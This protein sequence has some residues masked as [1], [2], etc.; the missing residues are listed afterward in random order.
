MAGVP[1]GV[2]LFERSLMRA[3]QEKA[4]AQ[5]QRQQQEQAATENTRYM[6]EMALKYGYHEDTQEGAA[7][8]A[9]ARA[10]GRVRE[11]ELTSRDRLAEMAFLYDLKGKL[12]GT[13]SELESGQI[14]QRAG[15]KMSQLEF[16][17]EQD[18]V[19]LETRNL[20]T[21]YGIDQNNATRM[22]IALMRD[23]RAGQNIALNERK[24][25]FK[26]TEDAAQMF[27]TFASNAVRLYSGGMG[28]AKHAKAAADAQLLESWVR[29]GRMTFSQAVEKWEQT[30]PS[31]KLG[32]TPPTSGALSTQPVPAP[33]TS[34]SGSS[35]SVTGSASAPV[36]DPRQEA[37]RQEA[38]KKLGL[39]P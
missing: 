8:N 5:Q 29:D 13:K 31:A 17:A 12:E 39:A 16:Q 37:V 6:T 35:T 20:M 32:N 18:K 11:K 30:Y 4:L 38:L 23:Q 15:H 10:Q 21:R 9:L 36:V 7:Q 14:D 34:A 25:D 2:T 1:L 24:F 27:T 26:S 22:A 3:E 19:E 33:G 28:G